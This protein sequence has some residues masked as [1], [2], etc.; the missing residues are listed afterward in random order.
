[1][2]AAWNMTRDMVQVA[3]GTVDGQQVSIWRHGKPAVT[4][5]NG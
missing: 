3:A 5:R 4:A 2:N 1:M